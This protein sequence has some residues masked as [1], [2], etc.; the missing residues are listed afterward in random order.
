M[1]DAQTMV[2]PR[3]QMS[4]RLGRTASADPAGLLGR[5]DVLSQAI[6]GVNGVQIRSLG[7]RDRMLDMR[8]SA[9]ASDAL[10]ELARAVGQRGLSFDVQSTV[11]REG[12]VDGLV[13]IRPA[14]AT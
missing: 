4:E 8:I 7:W 12:G 13:S 3:Q 9:P 11:P 5:L 10:S 2:D 6:V 1:P 14:G